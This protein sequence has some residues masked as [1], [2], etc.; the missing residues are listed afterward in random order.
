MEGFKIVA[1]RKNSDGDITDFKLDNAMELNYDRAVEM[2][3]SGQ[4]ENVDV[5]ERGGRAVIR[6]QRDDNPDN[7]LDRL[8]RF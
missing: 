2:A 5:Y 1:V 6:S 7:N 4:I 3:K 8:P